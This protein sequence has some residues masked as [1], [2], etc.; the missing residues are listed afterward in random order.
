M[1]TKNDALSCDQLVKRLQ[2]LPEISE[3]SQAKLA[4]DGLKVP[5]EDGIRGLWG[6]AGSGAAL[7]LVES[8]EKR[9]AQLVED[10]AALFL[11]E[12]GNKAF[13]RVWKTHEIL[14]AK[15]KDGKELFG[16]GAAKAKALAEIFAS[17]EVQ[18]WLASH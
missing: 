14:V 4:K 9:Y 12:D 17:P 11:S 18:A 2:D 8:L 6:M 7:Q 1:A 15:Y 16:G 10:D 3:R 5:D 13:I